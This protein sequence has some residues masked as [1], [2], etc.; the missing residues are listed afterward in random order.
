MLAEG[1]GSHPMF[2]NVPTVS[3]SEH[4]SETEEGGLSGIA[5][6]RSPWS[7]SLPARGGRVA[8]PQTGGE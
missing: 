1:N 8:G 6:R 2:V 7:L 4:S 3:E 5:K